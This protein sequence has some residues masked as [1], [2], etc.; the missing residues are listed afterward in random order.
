MNIDDSRALEEL[1]HW[2]V[3]Y[4]NKRE[5][6][7][8]NKTFKRVGEL[9]KPVTIPLSRTFKPLTD[10]DLSKKVQET[11]QVAIAGAFQFTHDNIKYTY[12]KSYILRAL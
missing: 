2:E 6:S 4:T 8:V 3:E 5:H 11:L 9:A 1:K 12:D 10:S 7:I